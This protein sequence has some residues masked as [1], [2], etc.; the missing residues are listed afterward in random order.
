MSLALDALIFAAGW[1][2]VALAPYTKVEESFNLHATHDVLMYGVRSANLQKYDHFTFPGAVPRTFIGSL[3]LA[4]TSDPVIRVASFFGLMSS[5]FDMQIIVRLVLASSNALGLC[6]IRRAV[7]RR[8]GR[9][10]G[11]LFTL[12]TISQFHIPFWMGR[13]LPNM[14]ALLPVNLA[15]YL[16]LDRAPNALN[17]TSRS[18]YAAV[19]LLTFA[20]VVYRA[21]LALLL[22]PIS[23]Q[24][25][26]QRNCSLN[27]LVKCGI[28]TGVVSI[29]LT[30]SV[31]T[32]FWQAP[33]L[34]WPELSGL[35]FNV[36]QGKSSEWGT[37]P[38]YT[39]FTAYLPKLLLTALPLSGLA[40]IFDHRIRSIL[41]PYISFIVLISALGHK[42]WRFI[43]YVVPIFN[44]AASRTA[45]WMVSRRK[46]W[47]IGRL[48][49][50]ALWAM[51]MANFALTVVVTF[52]SINN[53]PGGVALNHYNN[54]IDQNHQSTPPHVHISNLAAQSGASIFLQIHA[55]PFAEGLTQPSTW[56]TYNKT[57]GLTV[58]SLGSSKYFT[59]IISEVPPTEFGWMDKGKWKEIEVVEGFE[60]W[61]VDRQVL[62]GNDD[63]RDVVNR[64]GNVLTVV[65]SAQLWILERK[66]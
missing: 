22:A 23:L 44:V 53:Y 48:Y 20:G 60:R 34:L 14:F 6:F 31:D 66:S 56:T 51:I 35:Y 30:T 27:G 2:H 46:S 54:Y 28:I 37:S 42:E 33:N 11:L 65:K 49:F 21:E 39:Y 62:W 25:L 8:F 59:H 16:L 5:K 26:Y 55:P 1:I 32:Y 4:G 45:R 13:T 19:S 7:S 29:A 50:L 15:T 40:F 52:A 36:I 61:I 12:I 38:P 18:V 43:V 57:E 58:Q 17:P 64:L 9:L 10:T 41:L 24:A 63:L 3:I 47:F